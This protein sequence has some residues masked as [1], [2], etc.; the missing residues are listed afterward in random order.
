[1]SEGRYYVEGDFVID[2]T[3]GSVRYDDMCGRVGQIV[4]DL[5]NYVEVLEASDRDCGRVIELLVTAGFV[6]QAKVD[7]SFKLAR[8]LK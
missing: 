7:E 6:T 4:A 3:D 2:R 8:S 1:M 5:L